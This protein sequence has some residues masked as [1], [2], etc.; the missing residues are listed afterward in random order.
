MKGKPVEIVCSACGEET[1][2]IREAE[3]DGFTK[4]GEKLSCS[5]CGHRYDSEDDVPFKGREK[6]QVFS[7]SDRPE[8]VSVFEED[9]NA[10]L[11]RYCNHYVVNPFMQWCGF[12][13]KE[14]EATD[15]CDKFEPRKEEDSEEPSEG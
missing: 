7:E 8:D 10:R 5:A 14:V 15:T 9:E 6:V 4:V 2:L 12:H 11:C 1:L 3:Y 13:R